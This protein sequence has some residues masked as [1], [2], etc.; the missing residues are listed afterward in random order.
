MQTSSKTKLYKK[1]LLISITLTVLGLILAVGGLLSI[2]GDVSKCGFSGGN[3]AC[4]SSSVELHGNIAIAGGYIVAV[5]FTATAV[6]LILFLVA[7]SSRNRTNKP[8]Q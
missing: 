4:P 2:Y 6:F 1:I 3:G 8:A 7:R 5:G